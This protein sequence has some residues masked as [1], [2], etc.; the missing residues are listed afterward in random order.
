MTEL[1]DIPKEMPFE[2]AKETVPVVLAVCVP[3]ARMLYPSAPPPP[4]ATERLKES[5]LELLVIDPEMLAPVNPVAVPAYPL[6]SRES[7]E[8]LTVHVTLD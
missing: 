7:P 4:G 3:A 2:L 5:P 8:L 6:A 1:L